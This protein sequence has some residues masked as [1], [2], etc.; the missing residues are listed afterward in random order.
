MKKPKHSALAALRAA[1]KILTPRKAW[2][3]DNIARDSRGREVS[4]DSEKA[5]KFCLCGAL[6]RVLGSENETTFS[7]C[8]KA[9]LG[10]SQSFANFND[11]PERKHKEVLAALDNAIA[12]L[13]AGD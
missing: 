2:T 5:V 13:S 11:A 6:M 9:I 12:S 10:P 1:R 8:Q 4:W 7:Q 3:K